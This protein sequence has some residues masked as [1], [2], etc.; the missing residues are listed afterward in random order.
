MAMNWKATGLFA[1]GVAFGTAGIRLLTSRDAK[2]AYTHATAATLRAKD[3]VMK[4]V[5]TIQ[6]N[7]EDI[8]ADAKNINEEI[9]AAEDAAVVEEETAEE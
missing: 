5:S 4:T 1:A 6:E 9:Y 2:K 8:Y 3:C 7:C